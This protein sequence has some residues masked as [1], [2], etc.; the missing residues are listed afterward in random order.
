M[1]P[2]QGGTP[3]RA[4]FAV[5]ARQPGNVYAMDGKQNWL[6][7]VYLKPGITDFEAVDRDAAIRTVLRVDQDFEYELLSK[8]DW[9]RRRLIVDKV[10]D[11]KVFICICGDACHL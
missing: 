7:R 11:D 3:A 2:E 8:E 6:V 9:V 1:L 10:R 5:K 4:S